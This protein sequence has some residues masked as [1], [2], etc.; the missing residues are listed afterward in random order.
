MTEREK[1][2][3]GKLYDPFSEGMPEERTRAHLL[4]Q[5]YNA[6]AETDVEERELF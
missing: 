4:C 2:L 6:A 1:M 3:A 5:A